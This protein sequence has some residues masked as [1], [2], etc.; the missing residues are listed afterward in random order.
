MARLTI[1][2]V[3]AM[4]PGPARQEIPDSFL[5]GLYLIHQPSGAK[6]WAVRY[7]HQGIPRKLTL[8]SYPGLGLKDARELAAKARMPARGAS[9]HENPLAPLGCGG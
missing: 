9:D 3:E 6:G 4:K 7:R 2:S 8:G 5:P 1:R